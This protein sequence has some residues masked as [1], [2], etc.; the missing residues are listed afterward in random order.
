MFA[1]FRNESVWDSWVQ[2]WRELRGIDRWPLV[3]ARIE[4]RERVDSGDR[5]SY[6]IRLNYRVNDRP[7]LKT[8]SCTQGIAID[9]PVG[10]ELEIR[11]NPQDPQDAVLSDTQ[12]SASGLAILVLFIAIVLLCLILRAASH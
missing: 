10:E 3:S 1:P 12:N 9:T 6:L 8:L 4:D 7:F 2:R 5:T 11:V